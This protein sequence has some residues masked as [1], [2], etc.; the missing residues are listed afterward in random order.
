[1]TDR[2]YD[3]ARGGVLDSVKSG[4]S[5]SP[6]A[7]QNQQYFYEPGRIGS[8]YKRLDYLHSVAE[9]FAYDGLTRLSSTYFGS[10][11]AGT[12][13]ISSS[14]R[15]DY[16]YDAAGNLA[17]KKSYTLPDGQLMGAASVGTYN[18]FAKAEWAAGKG[19]HA[20]KSIGAGA[21][22][23]Y[24]G[25]GNLKTADDLT[26]TW[27]PFNQPDTITRGTSSTA[28]S[29]GPDLQRVRQVHGAETVDYASD[30][31]EART[32]AGS[33]QYV[34]YLNGPF[35]RMGEVTVNAGVVTEVK[36]F[37]HDHL[38][39]VD[40]IT[41]IDGSSQP[42]SF[43]PWGERRSGTTWQPGVVASTERRGFTDHEELDDVK[44]VNMNGRIYDPR[45]GRF[46]SVDP[47]Y[48]R[49]Y[50]TQGVNAYSYV[51]N[52]PL[53]YTDPTSLAG[54]DSAPTMNI[55]YQPGMGI[56]V[57]A[58]RGLPAWTNVNLS[59]S[60]IP[61]GVG[62]PWTPRT[63]LATMNQ[64]FQSGDARSGVASLLAVNTD[65]VVPE[66]A[67]GSFGNPLNGW[68]A[69][70]WPDENGGTFIAGAV[71]INTG[72]VVVFQGGPNL[73][74]Q[75]LTLDVAALIV[76]P[77]ALKTAMAAAGRTLSAAGGKVVAAVTEKIAAAE[78][79][80][81]PVLRFCFPAGTLVATPDGERQIED[82]REG[83]AVL[84]WDFDEQ[85]VV[86]K[87][88]TQVFARNA[89]RLLQI[90]FGDT[91]LK[92]T[93]NHPFWVKDSGWTL[94]E[95]LSP[96]MKLLALDG[97]ERE[98]IDVLAEE[99]VVPVF[100]FEVAG[101]NNYFAGDDPVLVHNQNAPH[102][103][104]NAAMNEALAWFKSQGVKPNFTQALEGRFG[105]TEGKL[106]GMY[107]PVAKARYRIEFD[108]RSGAHINVEIGKVKGPHIQFEGNA[109]SVKSILRQLFGCR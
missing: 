56:T 70:R 9:G 67:P 82:I 102:S 6:S 88:V 108:A 18:Y 96:G 86:T 31:H 101:T 66:D 26:I 75:D 73:G 20:I 91:A 106:Y 7:A 37:H 51:R 94:A 104:Y 11:A 100:N 30:S 49:L 84:S 77:P 12:T 23:T 109:N 39:S 46:L 45:L 13:N 74:A 34:H 61:S 99:K 80:S 54:T 72:Q 2:L 3:Q 17:S 107:D 29:Y 15:S 58:N 90:D 62:S 79:K 76:V 53:S 65:P 60:L 63:N 95:E 44:L 47:L 16:T 64:S 36:Y 92:T 85:K 78:S 42:Q 48:D 40:T 1:V 24:D 87:K 22:Y 43:D 68:V 38:G 25:N 10:V 105:V 8:L 81:A 35:G 71:N 27:T 32:T 52:N 14:Q 55:G 5:S 89:T 28:F 50:E 98:V 103:S 57:T 97:T 33:T 59:L 19:A 93:G 41:Q 4:L 83:D 21:T 69:T